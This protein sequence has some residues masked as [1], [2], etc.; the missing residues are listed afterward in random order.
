MKALVLAAGKGIRMRPYTND[1]PKVLIKVNGKPFL[2]YL[3]K[4]L[5]K[6]GISEIGLVVGYKKDKIRDF[7]EKENLDVTLIEQKKLFGTGKA[8]LEAKNW[9][10]DE[11]FIVLM[12]DN[13]YS[14]GDIRK[15]S[16]LDEN[17][18]YV[19]AYKSSHPEDYGVLETDGKSLIKIQEKPKNPKSNLINSGIY[20]FTP[21]IFDYLVKLQK[22]PRG[23]YE[24]TDAISHIA[25]LG[26]VKIYKLEEYWIDM[27]I[28]KDVSKMNERIKELE[29]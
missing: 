15:I 20:K 6:A 8:V 22:S 13:L 11:D 23:E 14:D 19:G 27:S 16:K 3:L 29:L 24:L 25:Q 7:I 1:K 17:F 26:K 10:G 5:Q 4:N 21:E 28:K 18:T 12:G 2:Y 9:I